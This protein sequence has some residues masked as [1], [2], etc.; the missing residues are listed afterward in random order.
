MRDDLS[1]KRHL[2]QEILP[3]E[4]HLLRKYV[5]DLEEVENSGTTTDLLNQ[6]NERI[7]SVNREINKIMEKKMLLQNPMDDKL[8][9]FQ[10]NVSIRLL[11]RDRSGIR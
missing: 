11:F 2:V 1:T 4:I 8:S 6:I 10:Q 7:S 3:R 9:I 5:Q